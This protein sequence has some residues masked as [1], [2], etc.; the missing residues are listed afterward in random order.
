MRTE[1]ARWTML[2]AGSGCDYLRV[3]CIEDEVACANL[4]DEAPQRPLLPLVLVMPLK[5]QP[6][7]PDQV[8]ALVHAPAHLHK[9]WKDMQQRCDSACHFAGEVT[10]AALLPVAGLS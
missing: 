3:G 2:Q 6:C 4:L 7:D 1:A 5:R 9:W 10:H 8:S